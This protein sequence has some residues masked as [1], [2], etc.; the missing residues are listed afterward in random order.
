MIFQIKP[1]LIHLDSQKWLISSLVDPLYLQKKAKQ[2]RYQ[3]KRETKLDL[4]TL[5]PVPS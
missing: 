2:A 5:G 3:I 1:L 4:K